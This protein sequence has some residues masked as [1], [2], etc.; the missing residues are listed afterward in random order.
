M[1]FNLKYP[2]KISASKLFPD[3]LM[4]PHPE[5]HV[6]DEVTQTWRNFPCAICR[7]ITSWQ[8]FGPDYTVPACSEECVVELKKNAEEL[9]AVLSV[10][11]F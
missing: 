11:P 2:D 8:Y 9:C 10:D 1:K 7:A 6:T 4:G 3:K 5:I